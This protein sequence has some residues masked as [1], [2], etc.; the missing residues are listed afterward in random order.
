MLLLGMFAFCFF[1]RFGRAFGRAF[2][3]A[4][5]LRAFAIVGLGGL[6]MFGVFGI[7]NDAFV[8][9]QRRACWAQCR[10]RGLGAFVRSSFGELGGNVGVEGLGGFDASGKFARCAFAAQVIV[11]VRACREAAWWGVAAQ[12]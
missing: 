4:F 8:V 9:V 1:D 3:C 2:G 6:D 5:G 12:C 10:R 7:V 11:A